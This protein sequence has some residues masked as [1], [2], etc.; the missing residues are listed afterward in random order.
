MNKF[1]KNMNKRDRFLVLLSIII[2]KLTYDYICIRYLPESN[3]YIL[4]VNATK[5]ILTWIVILLF[6]LYSGRNEHV[7][8][9]SQKVI[10]FLY[11]LYFIPTISLFALMDLPISYIVLVI[12]YWIFILLFQEYIPKF[13]IKKIK[14]SNLSRVI[15]FL[16]IATI[17]ITL[18]I[19]TYLYN[20]LKFNFNL[21]M[22]YEIRGM[23]A[24]ADIP[25]LINVL[26]YFASVYLYPILI[27]YLFYRKRW[28]LLAIIIFMQLCLFSIAMDK[29][30]LFIIPVSLACALLVKKFSFENRTKIILSVALV[31]I[32]IIALIE[33]ALFKSTYLIVFIVRRTFFVPTVLN[34]FYYDFM[35]GKEKL[36]FRDGLLLHRFFEPVHGKPIISFIVDQYIGNSAAA[37]NSGMF[38][39]AY[40]ECGVLGVLILPFLLIIVLRIVDSISLGVNNAI[41]LTC[42]IVMSIY[43]QNIF[44]TGGT[45]IYSYVLLLLFLYLMP[46][47]NGAGKTRDMCIS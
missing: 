25:K 10:F 47:M 16:F 20:G 2:F 33:D 24:D 34:Y 31:S 8:S 11:F 41:M 17:S 21:L 12:V 40:T 14:E 27:A 32:N 45:F 19:Y 13:K 3:Y 35:L 15:L 43:L 28:V 5:Y 18:F 42:T 9:F 37:P 4:N 44:I 29:M 38:A 6:S 36:L 23:A 26:R 30:A 7:M 22:T 46:R 1:D 39:E